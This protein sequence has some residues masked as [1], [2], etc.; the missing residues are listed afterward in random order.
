MRKPIKKSFNPLQ[1]KS[2]LNKNEVAEQLGVVYKRSINI[3]NPSKMIDRFHFKDIGQTMS[4]LEQLKIRLK[5]VNEKH[6][7]RRNMKMIID[8]EKSKLK[9]IN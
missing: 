9:L 7:A 8:L 1:N 4:R 6:K 3:L 2:K 5:Q